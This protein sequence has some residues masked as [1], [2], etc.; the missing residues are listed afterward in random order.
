M[1]L[2]F[3]WEFRSLWGIKF[4]GYLISLASHSYS[5]P[6]DCPFPMFHPL[7]CTIKQIFMYSNSF[8]LRDSSEVV[9]SSH[10]CTLI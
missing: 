5:D 6:I 3:D 9:C 10:Y 2:S 1:A 8:F 4:V 7:K